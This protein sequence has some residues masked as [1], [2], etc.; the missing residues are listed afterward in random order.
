ML[1]TQRKEI[2]TD[3]VEKKY[4]II[5]KECVKSCAEIFRTEF[6]IQYEF[7]VNVVYIY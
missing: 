5:I 6:R 2:G 7:A 3:N 4:V 1:L